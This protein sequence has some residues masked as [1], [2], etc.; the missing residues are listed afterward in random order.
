MVVGTSL[1]ASGTLCSTISW[2]VSKM[3]EAVT[4]TCGRAINGCRSAP[5]S[6]ALAFLPFSH[7]SFVRAIPPSVLGLTESH[8]QKG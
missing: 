3:T 5:D 4:M 8:G 1:R 6:A 7:S 2:K